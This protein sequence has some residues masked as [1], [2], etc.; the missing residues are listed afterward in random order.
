MFGTVS[1][2][3]KNEECAPGLVS[4]EHDIVK[5]K[6]YYRCDQGGAAASGRA[7]IDRAKRSTV[8]AGMARESPMIA[9][10]ASARTVVGGPGG[11]GRTLP[12]V[13]NSRCSTEGA[14]RAQSAGSALPRI[15]V[16]PCEMHSVAFRTC[17]LRSHEGLLC[18]PQQS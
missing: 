12:H 9:R 1:L 11:G 7:L 17:A 15:R 18:L 16:P 6:L 14:S 13:V 4:V 10:H 5:H 2:E 8:A 3:S